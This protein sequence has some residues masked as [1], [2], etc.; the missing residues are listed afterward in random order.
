VTA[1]V[2]CEPRR[3]VVFGLARRAI[4]R[5]EITLSNG[6]RIRPRLVRFP[7]ASTSSVFLAVLPSRV[8]VI[9]VRFLGRHRLDSTRTVQ[10]SARAPARQCGYEVSGVLP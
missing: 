10:L 1:R 5:V 7:R 4:G 2:S 9:R 3:T 8:A 6:R